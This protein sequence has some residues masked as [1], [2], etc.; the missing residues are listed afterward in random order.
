MY[1]GSTMYEFRRGQVSHKSLI[2]EIQ[3]IVSVSVTDNY[4]LLNSQKVSL[5]ESLSL[6]IIH[7]EIPRSLSLSIDYKKN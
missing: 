1:L 6:T 2:M 5:T 7:Y 3:K 4:Q